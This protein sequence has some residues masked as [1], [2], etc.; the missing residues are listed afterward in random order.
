MDQ[1]W[2]PWRLSYISA[3]GGGKRKG[4]PDE[5][6]AWPLEEDYGCVF[7]NMVASV[8]WA[9]DGGME[10]EE[11]EKAALILEQGRDCF[12]CLNR[13]PYSTGHVMIV[14]YKH[15]AS[16]ACLDASAAGEMIMISRRMEVALRETY[17]PDGLNLG[18]NL[19]EAA[20]AGIVDHLHLHELPRW[21]GD[22]NFITVTGQ[23]RVIPED[24][25]VTWRRL[26]IALTQLQL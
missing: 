4:V 11:A 8:R 24:L 12:V 26:R 13:Y 19:G 20:G 3:E 1:L 22:T 2:T 10:Q 14:P 5:L 18:M 15:E 16:L 21:K 17:Q 25:D 6:S 9:M 23:T 7:C